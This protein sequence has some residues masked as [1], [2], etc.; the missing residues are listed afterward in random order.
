MSRGERVLYTPPTLAGRQRMGTVLAVSGQSALIQ[1]DD[2]PWPQWA[3]LERLFK[4][5][6]TINDYVQLC[7]LG[8]EVYG[9]A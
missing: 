8:K 2:T 1:F 5:G 9:D 3:P 7:I 6:T 4:C